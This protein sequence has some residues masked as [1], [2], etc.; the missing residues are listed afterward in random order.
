MSHPL[1]NLNVFLDH[2]EEKGAIFAVGNSSY[3]ISAS[4]V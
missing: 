3:E 2:R 1:Y 4:K